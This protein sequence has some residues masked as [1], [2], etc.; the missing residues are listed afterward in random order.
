MAAGLAGGSP[1]R[2]EEIVIERHDGTRLTALVSIEPIKNAEGRVLG[3]VNVFRDNTAQHRKDEMLRRQ[4]HQLDTLLQA[5]PAAVYT[6]DAEGRITFFNEAAAALWGVRPEL[7][8]DRFCGSWKLYWPDGT[9]LPH[10]ECPMAMALKSRTPIRGKQAVAERPDG[11]RVP[12]L[13]YPTPLFD[14]AGNLTGA[15]NVLLDIAERKR[16]ELAAQH[17]AAIVES[18]HDAIV[19]KDINGIITS[20][21]LGAERLFGYTAAEAVGQPVTMLIPADRHDE[22]PMILSKIRKG[23]RVDHYETL[24]QRKDGSQIGTA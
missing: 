6:T 5:L 12:F 7:G 11:S 19:S 23:E 1:R 17:L 21:N 22:E 14:A 9:P 20:W 2:D 24:R 16:T 15:I 10:D 4:S 3:A 8:S 13:A 18:S